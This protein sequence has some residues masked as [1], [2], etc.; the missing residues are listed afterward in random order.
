LVAKIAKLFDIIVVTG[1]HSTPPSAKRHTADPVPILFWH[2]DVRPDRAARLC[3]LE[4]MTGGL[5]DIVGLD[6]MNLVLDY[7]G[8]A[9]MFG[10]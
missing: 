4:C 2:G 6:I 7:L 3:E 10:E 8:K 1:D 9:E 5:G